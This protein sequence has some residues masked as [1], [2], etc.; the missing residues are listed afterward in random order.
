MVTHQV[1]EETSRGHLG[2]L[3]FERE[4]QKDECIFHNGTVYRVR[5]MGIV[6]PTAERR[7]VL[8]VYETNDTCYVAR[9]E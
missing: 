5:W 4:I 6:G 2:D 3:E 1:I 7:R 9:L 8:R